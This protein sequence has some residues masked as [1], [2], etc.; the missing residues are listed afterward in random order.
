[1]DEEQDDE[2]IA[3]QHLRRHSSHIP[4]NAYRIHVSNTG[5]IISIYTDAENDETCCVHYPLLDE[6]SLP[7][8]VRTVRRDMLEKLERLGPDADL[9]AYP[10]CSS[11]L[12][13][14]HALTTLQLKMARVNGTMRTGMM[15][16]ASS[17]LYMRLS[18]ETTASAMH[19]TR[20]KTS[21]ASLWSG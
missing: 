4:L 12:I 3:I 18:L 21:K 16:K 11:T 17:S 2:S 20:N 1:M 15:S 5:E 14:P 10:P 6:I 7:E 19:L 13:S 9:V 8:G